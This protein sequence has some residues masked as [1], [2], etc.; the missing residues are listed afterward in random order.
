MTVVLFG[1]DALDPEL[2]NRNTA[3]MGLLS[4]TDL[5]PEN[6]QRNNPPRSISFLI[7]PELVFSIIA[8]QTNEPGVSLSPTVGTN[9]HK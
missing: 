6:Y 5:I 9:I 7:K 8:H 3:L 1:I 2:V 4:A